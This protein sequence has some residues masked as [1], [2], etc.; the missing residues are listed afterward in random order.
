MLD[1]DEKKIVND[2]YLINKHKN[3]KRKKVFKAIKNFCF[4]CG[5]ILGLIVLI[6]LYFV[7]DYSKIYHISV[8]GNIYLKDK[9]IIKISGIDSDDRFILLI[10]NIIESRLNNSPYIENAKVEKLDGNLI[11]ITVNEYKQ[12]A[13]FYENYETKLLLINN[14]R[15]SLN[16]DNLYLINNVPL[17]EGYVSEQIDNILRGFKQIDYSVINE[18]SEIHRYPFSYDENMLEVI[19]KDGNFCFLSWTGLSM[20]NDYYKINSAFDKSQGNVCIYLD[21]LTKSGYASSCPWQD[22]NIPSDNDNNE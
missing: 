8:H 1:Y 19:M 14:D 7:S 5:I 17:L 6:C 20:L 2:N 21:E 15:I 11:K 4:L 18:I 13:Y 3:K 12:V 9:D 22:T 10:P 16:E